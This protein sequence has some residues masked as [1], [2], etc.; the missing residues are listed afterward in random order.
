MQQPHG[1]VLHA[2]VSVRAGHSVPPDSG[3]VI[4]VRVLV[5]VPPLHAAVH[6]ENDVHSLTTQLVGGETH[7]A[8]TG[9]FSQI[10]GKML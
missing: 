5:W 8:P 1:L 4:T 9:V 2:T 7:P 3:A 10:P 6:V